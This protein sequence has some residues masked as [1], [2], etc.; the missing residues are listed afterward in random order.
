[1]TDALHFIFLELGRLKADYG[2]EDKCKTRL[3]RFAYTWR[4]GRCWAGNG[5]AIC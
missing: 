2:E 5:V 4:Y 1:M 3:E